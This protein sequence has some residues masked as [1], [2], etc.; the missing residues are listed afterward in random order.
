MLVILSGA[1]M[2]LHQ[3]RVSL[4]TNLLLLVLL[5]PPLLALLGGIKKKNLEF[6]RRVSYRVRGV[7][8][9]VSMLVAYTEKF[10]KN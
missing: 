9:L 2:L 8:W 3:S 6:I 7:D 4:L 5:Y 1:T 10:V